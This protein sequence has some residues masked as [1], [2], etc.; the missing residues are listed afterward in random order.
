MKKHPIDNLFARK[1]KEQQRAP[2]ATSWDMLEKRLN[3]TQRSKK[4]PAIWWSATAAAI[5]LLLSLTYVLLQPTTES[6]SF[7][8]ARSSK[9]EKR[10]PIAPPELGSTPRKNL[11]AD[12]A[13]PSQ[14]PAATKDA[15]NIVAPKP[16]EP[17][18]LASIA[19]ITVKLPKQEEKPVHVEDIMVDIIENSTMLTQQASTKPV[20]ITIKLAGNKTGHSQHIASKT[21]FNFRE[22]V[23]FAKNVKDG[24]LG[25]EELREA[26]QDLLKFDNKRNNNP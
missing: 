21:G 26:K 12:I 22:F 23:A 16:E 9:V 10:S 20:K 24:E 13:V 1:L 19:T 7:T 25:L 2:A 5:A 3:K 14:T 4:R 11:L 6:Q 8:A 15:D 18:A 17:K